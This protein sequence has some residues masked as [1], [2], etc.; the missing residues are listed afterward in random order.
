VHHPKERSRRSDVTVVTSAGR[1]HSE[2][3]V[4]RQRRYLALQFLRVVCLLM[5]ATVPAGMI[6]RGVLFLLAIVLP[7][8]G[9]VMANAGP[10]RDRRAPVLAAPAVEVPVR[11]QIAAPGRVVDGD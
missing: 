6:V 2:D 1:S 7:Y 5:A 4:V 3:I 8:F 10:S 9:V 11:L